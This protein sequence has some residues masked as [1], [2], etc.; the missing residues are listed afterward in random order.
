MDAIVGCMYA[1]EDCMGAIQLRMYA[2]DDCLGAIVV[3]MGANRLRELCF[4][5]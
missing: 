3:C 1:G 2:D 4:A 5:G